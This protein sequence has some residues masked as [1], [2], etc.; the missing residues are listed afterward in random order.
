MPQSGPQ[1]QMIP[2][3]TGANV[4][5]LYESLHLKARGGWNRVS[6]SQCVS[7][8]PDVHQGRRDWTVARAILM[9]VSYAIR[10]NIC[11]NSHQRHQHHA[12]RSRD[13][14]RRPALSN[15]CNWH[16]T[17]RVPTTRKTRLLTGTINGTGG[18]EALA[19]K[20]AL[21][22]GPLRCQYC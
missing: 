8:S 11:R 3:D 12:R 15:P 6:R 14:R 18:S 1:G 21:V 2:Y 9:R 17:C 4:A 10:D 13:C 5:V 19:M 7:L 22:T 16:S 20:I